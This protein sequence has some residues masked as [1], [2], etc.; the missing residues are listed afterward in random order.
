MVG[1][2]SV[3]AD[4]VLQDDSKVSVAVPEAYVVHPFN[5]GKT[6]YWNDIRL[7]TDESFDA[8]PFGVR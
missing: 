7:H 8:K 1:R 6:V 2:H 4:Y 3:S 5:E